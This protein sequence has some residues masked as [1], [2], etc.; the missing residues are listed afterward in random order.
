MEI[1]VCG[2]R[3]PQNIS[4]ILVLQ[5]DYIG[6]IFY[7]GSRRYVEGNK[8]FEG[9]IKDIKNVKKTGVF[10]HATEEQVGHNVARYGLNVVQLHGEETP[11]YCGLINTCTPV[12]KAFSIDA[13]FDFK[14]LKDY[15]PVCTRFLFDT[16]GPGYGG[17]GRSFDWSLLEDQEI[18][19]PFLL[20]GGIGPGDADRIKKINHPGFKGIDINSRFEITPGL[21]DT[22]LVKNF[23]Y[24]IRN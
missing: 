20:S 6:L 2:L 1:K 18:P 19:L 3:E 15:A 23:I 16:P 22:D 8:E 13:H 11:D 7:P 4:D 12:W 10:V 5:P 21:K 9:F 17:T 24:A 14:Q